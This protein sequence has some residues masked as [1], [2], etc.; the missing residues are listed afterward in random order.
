ML[1]GG[2]PAQTHHGILSFATN[3]RSLLVTTSYYGSRTAGADA[4]WRYQVPVVGLRVVC[5]V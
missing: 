2:G 3:R 4:T 1:F 5:I